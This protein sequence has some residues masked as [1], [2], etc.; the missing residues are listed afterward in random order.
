MAYPTGLLERD[1]YGGWDPA[2]VDALG[3]AKPV[4]GP[5]N[6]RHDKPVAATAPI[7]GIWEPQPGPQALAIGAPFINELLFGG[8]RGGGKS[9]F[10][11]GDFL[12]DIGLGAVWQGIIF[13]KSYPELD[14]LIKRAREIFM[15]LGA[16]YKVQDKTFVFPSGAFLKMRHVEHERDAD[17]YQGHQY[18]WIGWDELGNWPNLNAYKKLKAC[19]RSAHGVPNKRI[20]CSANPGGVGHHAVKAYFIDPAPLGMDMI[21]SVDEDGTITTRMFIPSR[22]YDNAILLANDPQYIARLREI[23]SPELVKAWLEGDWNVITGAYF[24]EFSTDKH[25]LEPFAIPDHW[26]RFRS[27][28]WGS[29]SPFCVLWHAVSDGY[30]LPNGKYIPAGAV[31]TY[32][33]WYGCAPGKVNEGLKFT[34]NQVGKGIVQRDRGERMSFA[35]ADPSMFK[36]DGGPSHAENMSKVGAQWS[37]G[38][39]NR[40]AGWDQVR[41]RLCGIK[42]PKAPGD[43]RAAP[44]KEVFT[45]SLSDIVAHMMAKP[46]EVEAEPEVLADDESMVGTPMWY[47]FKTCVHLIRTLPALQHDMDNP[48]DCD[49]DGE[50]HAPDA[51]RYG[52]MGRPWTRPKPKK[53]TGE[54][55]L[56]QDATLNDIWDDHFA[57]TG[58]GV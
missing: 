57:H 14:E 1:K 2:L 56:L 27:M 39:N 37:K 22:V 48:E 38:D 16:I 9:D 36:W 51:L 52:L 46:A 13:R 18:T 25:V 11:L 4:T 10:L 7:P 45:G 31:V 5:Q 28:D 42:E 35:K 24:P 58:T 33:E 3:T 49:T 32:R 26:L 30:Q 34:S 43:V 29:S 8:A 6:P 54:I 20:R 41:D 23:G 44:T 50:D 21:Q 53:G 17:L 15:P 55:L 19:L 40:I 47:C 12:Q